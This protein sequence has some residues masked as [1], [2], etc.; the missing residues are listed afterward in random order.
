MTTLRRTA[1]LTGLAYLALALAGMTG[2]LGIRN[3]LYV[4]DDAAETVANLVEHET[5]ARLG[6]ASDLFLVVFQCL[7]ALGF[8]RLYR[9]IDRWAAG[10]LAAFGFMNSVAIMAATMFSVGALSAA[11][12]G[13]AAPG[14]DQAAT[15]ALLADLYDAAWSTGSLFFG[16]WLVP[17]GW[18]VRRSGWGPVVMAWFLMVGGVGYVL[19]AF[20]A[21]LLP[22]AT[23]LTELLAGPATVGELWMVAYLLVRGVPDR[24]AS[25]PDSGQ[26]LATLATGS[27]PAPAAPVTAPA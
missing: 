24:V 14:G 17:M 12:D 3:L 21:H 7:A 20:S 19:S 13:A 25:L 8:Y 16:L 1:R 23:V 9:R 11:L 6:I 2:F 26:P 10:S 18:L 15:V 4:P 5:L 27:G 22:D